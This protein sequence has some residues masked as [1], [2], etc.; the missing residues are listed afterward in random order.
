M[1]RWPWL[2]VGEQSCLFRISVLS[3]CQWV[4]LALP[5]FPTLFSKRVQTEGFTCTLSLSFSLC[6][7]LK[8]WGQPLS[9]VFLTRDLTSQRLIEDPGWDTDK[10]TEVNRPWQKNGNGPKTHPCVTPSLNSL[11]LFSKCHPFILS[12]IQLCRMEALMKHL[13]SPLKA[14][15]A[16]QDTPLGDRDFVWNSRFFLYDYIFY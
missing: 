8:W 4:I 16:I 9:A 5:R 3:P 7:R 2:A 15:S 13:K 14:T 6:G 11:H 1:A 12:F 10:E